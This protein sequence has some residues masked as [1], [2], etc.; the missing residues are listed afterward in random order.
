LLASDKYA[1][2][3][4]VEID[5]FLPKGSLLAPGI[6]FANPAIRFGDDVIILG[7]NVIGVGKAKMSGIEMN[8]SSRGVAVLP[9][10]SKYI[11]PI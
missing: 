11:D 10:H 3:Y 5:N 4:T 8:S 6:R 2:Q 7:E 1:G 9:R